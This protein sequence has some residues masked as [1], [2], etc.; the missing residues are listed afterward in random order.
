MERVPAAPSGRIETVGDT[1]FDDAPLLVAYAGLDGHLTALGGPW[2][3]L[4]GWSNHELTTRPFIEFVHPEDI[5]G[6]IAEMVSLNEGRRTVAFRNR[7]RTKRGTWTWL[8]WYA[9][10]TDDGRIAAIAV[11]V[12]E[13]VAKEHELDRRRR[14]FEIVATYQQRAL[15]EGTAVAGLEPALAAVCEVIGAT[16]ATVV[17][18]ETSPEGTRE[19]VGLAASGDDG[20][21]PPGERRAVIEGIERAD[22]RTP[23]MLEATSVVARFGRPIITSWTDGRV[24][25]ADRELLAIPLA[26]DQA[27]GIVTFTRD[28]GSFSISDIE[29]LTPLLGAFA[30][31]IERDRTR[32]VEA[33]MA[34]EVGRL[35][36]MLG[37]MLERSEF[38]VLVTDASGRIELL[39]EAATRTL[40]GRAAVDERWPIDRLLAPGATHGSLAASL[41]TFEGGATDSEWTFVDRTGRTIDVV[42]TASA[43]FAADGTLRGWMLIG[44][45][46]EDHLRAERDRLERVR[47]GAQVE[48]LQR[49]EQQ[50]AALADA[51]QYVVASHTHREALDVIE[52]FLP[53]AFG[54]GRARLMRVAG[55]E[56]SDQPED[57]MVLRDVDCWAI[58][59]GRTFRS[60]PGAS[61]RCS[62]V[63]PHARAI[64]APLGDGVTSTGVIVLHP[65]GD[66]DAITVTAS[67][68]LLDD[69]ARQL[70]N[71]M[72]NLRLRRALEE[73]AFRDP[74][75]GVGNRRA[76]DEALT[77]ALART[78]S[79]GEPFAVVMVDLDKFKAVNDEHGHDVGDEV[80][81]RFAEFLRQH[82]RE[83]DRVARIGGEEF[84]LVLRDIPRSA[85]ERTLEALRRGVAELSVHPGLRLTASFGGVHTM[86]AETTA[87]DL[88]AAADDL[89]YAAKHG[90]RDRVEVADFEPASSHD[91]STT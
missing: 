78:R 86:T 62:H 6:T 14:L 22:G 28:T 23:T 45:T 7:Y 84:L 41:A 27:V 44:R 26:R 77:T 9:R 76:A 58:R 17:T 79:H 72:A 30:T 38:L 89:M 55:V 43:V 59:T 50:L 35:S 18:L 25:R 24:T 8:Q 11:D 75:T 49:R 67:E 15:I 3:A 10:P 87:E 33:R 66:A 63:E 12:T 54:A 68:A 39:N 65:D 19:L 80:L 13:H 16:S 42:I 2:T 53:S 74:L 83:D 34:A 29:V 91:R 5:G 88:V 47:L 48:L 20:F 51:T 90:G 70:S 21:C 81:V 32:A 73:Q 60:E 37:T 57:P 56:R 69:V 46:A 31:A 1:F 85:L 61:V 71:A 82:T 52:H 40:G 36:S 4:L 64:C